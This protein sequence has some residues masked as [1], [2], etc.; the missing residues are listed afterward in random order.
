MRI[1]PE[2]KLDEAKSTIGVLILFLIPLIAVGYFTQKYFTTK[3]EKNITAQAQTEGVFEKNQIDIEE[4][5]IIQGNQEQIDTTWKLLTRWNQGTVNQDSIRLLSDAG[6]DNI[7]PILHNQRTPGLP[8]PQKGRPERPVF[9]RGGIADNYSK[10][11]AKSEKTEFLRIITAISKI[12]ENEG[13]TQVERA[14][15]ILPPGTTPYQ[16]HATYLNIDLLLATPNTIR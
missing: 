6:F 14:T 3:E 4:I 9:N 10:I 12:E 1:H 7:N 2:E 8:N 16:D 13:L 11:E 15:L 5:R